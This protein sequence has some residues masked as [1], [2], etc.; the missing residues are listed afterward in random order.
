[1]ETRLRL[2]IV[3]AGLP[4]P[5]VNLIFRRQDGDWKIRLD[6][7]YPDHKS[8]VEYDGRHHGEDIDQWHRD[9]GRREYL[10]Q[11]GGRLIVVTSP[12]STGHPKRC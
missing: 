8:A 4:E 2:L 11:R 1:M 6:L 7:R 3:L 5:T 9:L 12:N 10:E